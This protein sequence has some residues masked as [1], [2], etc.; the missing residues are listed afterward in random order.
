MKQN[1]VILG[2]GN[3]LCRDDGIGVHLVNQLMNEKLP[4]DIHLVDAGVNTFDSLVYFE[5][6]QKVIILDALKGG[7]A[8]ATIYNLTAKDIEDYDQNN[9]SLHDVQ[10]LDLIKMAA[11]LNKE[12]QVVIYGI[13]PKDTS[14]GMDLST[15]LQNKFSDLVNYLKN[16]IIK[17]AST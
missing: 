5:D 15:E 7:Q 8:P 2:I 6:F 16:E 12:P 11:L 14:L 17:Q 9:L 1:I 10:I 3:I 13:E 4:A